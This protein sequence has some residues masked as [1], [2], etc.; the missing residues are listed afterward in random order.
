MSVV[1]GALADFVTESAMTSQTGLFRALG[2]LVGTGPGSGMCLQYLVSGLGY[3]SIVVIA[4][5][6]PTIRDGEEILPDHDQREKVG[7]EKAPE[8]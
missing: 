2:W 6:I 1:A 8:E 4:W 5:F 7:K 3:L